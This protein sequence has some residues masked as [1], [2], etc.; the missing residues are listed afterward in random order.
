MR[1]LTNG[2]LV[3]VLV[4]AVAAWWCLRKS[5]AGASLAGIYGMG[6]QTVPG[7]HYGGGQ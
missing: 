4:I 1:R 6:A 3:L 7:G 2:H 5:G